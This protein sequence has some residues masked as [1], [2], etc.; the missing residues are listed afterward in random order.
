MGDILLTN[1]GLFTLCLT[2]VALYLFTRDTLPLETSSLAV[3]I[4]LV[5]V[6]QFFPFSANGDVVGPSFF[7]SGFGN[8]A[9]VAVCALMV[10]GKGMETTGALQPLAGIIAKAWTIRPA[11]AMLATLVVGAV[12]SAFLNNTPIVVLLL[13]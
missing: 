3:L 11:L 7:F 1:H 13:P 8:E 4:L 5:A 6:F 12:L 9:L 10:V 2:A